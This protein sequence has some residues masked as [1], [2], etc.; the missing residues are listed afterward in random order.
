MEKGVGYGIAAFSR[1]SKEPEVMLEA[2]TQLEVLT[3]SA[4]VWE[5]SGGAEIREKMHPHDANIFATIVDSATGR[6]EDGC[7]GALRSEAHTVA[8]VQTGQKET[9]K[10]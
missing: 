7:R 3:N 9:M 6:R 8:R 10:T 2:G 5:S 4:R 1:V